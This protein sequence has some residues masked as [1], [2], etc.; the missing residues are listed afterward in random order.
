MRK[1]VRLW[2]QGPMRRI[3]PHDAAPRA[4]TRPLEI[5]AARGETQCL[6][7]GVRVGGFLFN[8]IT[9][10]VG[11]FLNYWLTDHI[12]KHDKEYVECLQ[13]AAIEV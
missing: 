3:F 2:T 12:L 6:Q 11:E 10:D 7:V 8:Y 13:N 4:R 1:H 9:A 5:A